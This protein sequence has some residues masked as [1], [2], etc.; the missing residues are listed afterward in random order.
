MPDLNSVPASPHSLAASRRQS[1]HQMPPPASSQSPSLNI[2]PSNQ[3]VV[4]HG[5][6]SHSH[7]HS[8]HHSL[9][10]GPS[11]VPSP[12]L[13]ASQP[14]Q[15]QL[16]SFTEPGVGP[17]PGPLRHPRPLTAAELHTQLEKE[18]EA[19][20]NRL[21]RELSLLRA[22]QNASVVSNTSSTSA[23]TSTHDPIAEASLLSGSG[24]S[25]PT[26]RRHHRNSSSASQNIAVS[27][28]ASS[29]EAR[30]H[31]PARP[32]QPI[33][34]SRQDS[35]ASRRSQT[36]SPGPQVS[37][38]DPSSYFHQQRVPPAASVPMSSVAATPGS[39]SIAD[40]MSPGMMAATTR[41]EETA[42]YRSELETAK[43]ENE[44]LKRRIRDLERMLQ[45][46]RASETSRTRSESVSTTASASVATAG[47][48]GIAGPRDVVA[49][50][51]ERGRGMTSQ[52]VAS[53]SSVG[54]GVPEDE[55]KVGESAASSGVGNN[56]P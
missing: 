10:H 51:P 31:I 47:G 9:S 38:L 13:A 46:R 18:Q 25:I 54:V 52:S 7:T 28:L 17:G 16:A 55:V 36:N 14:L 19:V 1:S 41:Y 32:P 11:S 24:F 12:Q 5:H 3:D 29:Y 2:L 42:F 27:Q 8:R 43:K 48:A 49:S 56:Q 4:S 44:A 50:R 22:A 23:A 45:S 6:S 34:L 37:S 26:T 21:T 20:V 39:G 30:H 40:Q 53:V 15:P 33:P 35:A